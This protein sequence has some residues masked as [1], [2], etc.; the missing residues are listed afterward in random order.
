MITDPANPVVD[1]RKKAIGS[2]L[3]VQAE[4]IEE[5]RKIIENDIYVTEGVVSSQHLVEFMSL[6]KSQWDKEKL[7]IAPFISATPFPA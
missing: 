3:I 7:L 5:V 2:A 6:N 1:G 4:N